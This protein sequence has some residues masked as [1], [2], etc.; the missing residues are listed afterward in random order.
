MSSSDPLSCPVLCLRRSPV[1]LT[2]SSPDAWP[3]VMSKS[4][5]AVL[6]V[7]RPSLCTKVLSV[8]ALSQ[9]AADIVPQGLV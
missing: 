6:G 4:S 9:K 7:F 1:A 2:M 3:V 5:F 8:V